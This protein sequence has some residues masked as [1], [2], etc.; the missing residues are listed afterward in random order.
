MV[1]Y[2]PLPGK[3]Y[4]SIKPVASMGLLITIRELA[5]VEEIPLKA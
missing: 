5:P 3:Q 1:F 2:T 4:C